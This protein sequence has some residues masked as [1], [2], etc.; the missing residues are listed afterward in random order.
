MAGKNSISI[1]LLFFIVYGSVAAWLP[2]LSIYLKDVGLSGIQIGTLL[3]IQP[4]FMVAVLPFW[5]IAADKFGRKKVLLFTLF[6]QSALILA[7]I[8]KGGY[9]YYFAVLSAF[10]L[11]Y[12]GV[13]ALL[14]SI[15]LDTVES[16]ESVQYSKL[17]MW[18]SIGWSVSSL[19]VGKIVSEDSLS[20]MFVISSIAGFASFLLCWFTIKK[21]VKNN[22]SSPPVYFKDIKEVLKNK[23][24]LLFMA[25]L[26]VYGI[27]TSTIYNFYSIYLEEIGATKEI[28]GISFSIQAFSE[29]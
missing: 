27:G 10:M 21:E 23:K 28:T 22:I 24:I 26:L 12:V 13:P 9:F 29:I 7:V 18:G 16:A 1:S 25:L 3:S 4:A 17:R 2:F 20:P 5:G 14:D 8:G 6:L 11:F 15:A 19:L